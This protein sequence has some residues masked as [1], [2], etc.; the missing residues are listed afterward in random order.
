MIVKAKRTG[1]K[2]KNSAAEEELGLIETVI[3]GIVE[4]RH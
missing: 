2:H 4:D 1:I 3:V